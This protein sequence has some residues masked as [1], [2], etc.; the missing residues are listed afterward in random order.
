MEDT[1]NN[2]IEEHMFRFMKDCTL[3]RQCN[4]LWC[5]SDVNMGEM[6]G[7]DTVKDSP[8]RGWP[9]TRLSKY[10]EV[11]IWIEWW[12]CIWHANGHMNLEC[13]VQQYVVMWR[14]TYRSSHFS[15]ISSLNLV[16]LLKVDIWLKMKISV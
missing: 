15:S 10:A 5:N 12:P 2:S 3:G 8:Q 9:V 6:S 7:S 14:G 16:M 4:K 11:A 1:R 13:L